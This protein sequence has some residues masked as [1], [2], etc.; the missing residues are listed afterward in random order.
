MTNFHLVVIA[1]ITQ[2]TS[3]G[4]YC[5]H[6]TLHEMTKIEKEMLILGKLHLL[7]R[8][9]SI[10]HARQ[11]TARKCKRVT[12]DYHF[13]NRSVCKDGLKKK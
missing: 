2:F 1:Q 3:S 4:V 7:S 5:F 9:G 11:I 12:C 13:D 8:N 6:L 10:Q